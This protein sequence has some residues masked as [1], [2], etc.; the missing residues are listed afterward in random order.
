MAASEEVIR[1]RNEILKSIR[2]LIK[3]NNRHRTSLEMLSSDILFEIVYGP[4]F[5]KPVDPPT[6]DPELLSSILSQ[7]PRDVFLNFRKYIFDW[8][9][10][11]IAIGCEKSPP[12]LTLPTVLELRRLFNNFQDD[13]PMLPAS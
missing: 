5:Q 12:K 3:I 4:D 13:Q 7:L 11:L 2:R 1:R 6:P 8:N 10:H 9:E